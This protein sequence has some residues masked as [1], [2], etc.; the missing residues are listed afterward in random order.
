MRAG[1]HSEGGI[2]PDSCRHEGPQPREG[3]RGAV[4][5]IRSHPV[6]SSFETSANPGRNPR[7]QNK[8]RWKIRRQLLGGEVLGGREGPAEP[9]LASRLLRFDQP[10]PRFS[11]PSVLSEMKAK[12]GH[13]ES[14]EVVLTHRRALRRAS[15]SSKWPHLELLATSVR[16]HLNELTVC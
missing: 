4:I 11:I 15:A 6:A 7:P 1:L 9:W 12:V 14:E 5:V 16:A 3:S 8:R 10:K 2:C 13:P